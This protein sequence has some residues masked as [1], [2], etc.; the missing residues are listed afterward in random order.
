MTEAAPQDQPRRIRAALVRLFGRPCL[1]RYVLWSLAFGLWLA[2]FLSL[3]QLVP[4]LPR[5]S[6]HAGKE[7]ALVAFSPDGKTLAT[8]EEDHSGFRNSCRGPIQL[9]NV[10][11]GRLRYAVARDERRV[12]H[13]TF[14]PDGQ[15]LIAVLEGK[16]LQLWDT[17]TGNPGDCIDLE[18]PVHEFVSDQGV[19]FS[20]D[21]RFIVVQFL[22]PV[23]TGKHTLLLLDV[24]KKARVAFR[25]NEVRVAF[26]PDGKHLAIYHRQDGAKSGKV[27]WWKLND[28]FPFSGPL[29]EFDIVADYCAFA[30]TLETFATAT[31]VKDSLDRVRVQLWDLGTGKEVGRATAFGD[32]G[33]CSLQ[34]SPTGRFLT[35]GRGS[36][37]TIWEVKQGLKEVASYY[38]NLVLSRD[39]R[40]F[41]NY[42]D[43]RTADVYCTETFHKPSVLSG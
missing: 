14:S 20:P 3:C 28:G 42:S 22:E 9:W 5:V 15:L 30:P 34:F 35:L 40:W 11:T 26:A 43:T 31:C 39:D 41:L 29:R 4:P 10:N 8:T 16:E 19:T 17:A 21:G 27:E 36:Q 25:D 24:Q 33:L 1:K 38:D 12:G 13:I 32:A 6:I 18:L 7:P 23:V 2:V 37:T